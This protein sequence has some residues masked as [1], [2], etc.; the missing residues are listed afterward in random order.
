MEKNQISKVV[1]YIWFGHGEKSELI[2]KCMQSTFEKLTDWKI[3]EWTEEDYDISSC[4]YCKEAYQMKKYAF[5][6]DYARFDILYRYGG[7]YVDTDVEL[8]NNIPES[9]LIDEGFAGVEG[10]NKIAPGL[11]FACKPGNPIVKEILE[12]Y[13]QDCFILSDGKL[14]TKTVVDRVTNIFIKH[15]FQLNG[16]EQFIEG[17][18]IYPVEYFCGYD[19]VTEQFTITDKTI[20]IHH[21]TATWTDKK[22]KFKRKF[23]TS[24]RNLMGVENYKK[25]IKI[26]R[27]LFGVSGE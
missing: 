7:V 25:M 11:I 22:S 12:T 2:K 4:N 14:N 19:F 23:K 10:N 20:S 15:G 6:S 27:M 5:A 1:H 8:L 24:L 18:H 17:F 9:F 26:K 13:Q 21:Y 16:K 3:K